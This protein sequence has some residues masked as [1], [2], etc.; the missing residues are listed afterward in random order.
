MSRLQMHASILLIY[1]EETVIEEVLNMLTNDNLCSGGLSILEFKQTN[2]CYNTI[3]YYKLWSRQSYEIRLRHQ[4]T[5]RGGLSKKNSKM[6][7]I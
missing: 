4:P 7:N 1:H 5:E 6:Y 2:I 3:S